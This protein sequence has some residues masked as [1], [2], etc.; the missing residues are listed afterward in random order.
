VLTEALLAVGSDIYCEVFPEP[1]SSGLGAYK[2]LAKWN[3]SGWS[4]L[5]NTY[6]ISGWGLM[7][8]SWAQGS[9]Y[10]A[11]MLVDPS[12]PTQALNFGR[13]APPNWVRVGGGLDYGLSVMQTASD[14][15]NLFVRG[16]FTAA[17]GNPA[18][19]FAVWSG[20]QWLTPSSATRDGA[21]VVALTSNPGEVLA[22]EELST[23]TPSGQPIFNQ[24]LV[25]YLG[26]NRTVLAQGD[27]T[28]M[29]L[30]RRTDDGIYCAG[31]FRVVGN[32]PT[33]N[34]ALWNGSNWARVGQGSFHGLNS[35]ATCLAVVG[36]N[37]FAGGYFPI[38]RR[39]LG[40]K[41]RAVGRLALAFVGKRSGW[42]GRPTRLSRWRPICC[43]LLQ[44]GE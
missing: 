32:V 13:L 25:Q 39:N 10:G 38:R 1:N 21:K 28:G 27:T 41:Y 19:G 16:D 5:A 24:R 15:T 36:T 6:M 2:A 7:T 18:E 34:L 40:S 12:N 26:T 8:L 35:Q 9:F 43:R 11:G 20:S 31:S 22:S 42:N 29:G 44:L 30:M 17:G 4:I 23:S 33:G 3:T 37:L 14:G